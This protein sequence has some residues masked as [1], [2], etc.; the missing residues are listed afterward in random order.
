[1]GCFKI[2]YTVSEH[3]Q[4]REYISCLQWSVSGN[5]EMR[6]IVVKGQM[7]DPV[8]LFDATRVEG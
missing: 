8:T 1:M 4:L 7:V 6:H 5:A 2:P 3:I